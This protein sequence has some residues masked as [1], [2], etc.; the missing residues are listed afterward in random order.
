VFVPGKAKYGGENPLAGVNP[1]FKI[2][3]EGLTNRNFFSGQEID[4]YMEKSLAGRV[5]KQGRSAIPQGAALERYLNPSPAPVLERSG[6]QQLINQ[7][8]GLGFSTVNLE[9]MELGALMQ[10][11]AEIDALRS[12]L[13][14]QAR[15]EAAKNAT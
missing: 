5:W 8:V 3:L 6:K 15:V 4:P 12:K 10:Q 9:N 13:R 14:R 2:P 7:A 1:L 11:K